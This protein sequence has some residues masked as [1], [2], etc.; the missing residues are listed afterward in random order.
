MFNPQALYDFV[1]C[2]WEEK[3]IPSLC[4]YIRIP[5]KSPHFD[6]KWQEHGL[7]EQAV[8]HIANWCKAHG[9]KG[10][11]LEIMRLKGRT[12]LIFIEVPGVID[13]TVLLYGHLDKQ[14]EM[15]GWNEDLHP[16]KPV[17]KNGRLY[18][19]G[20][21]DD[22]YA[23]YASL[24]AIC[25]LQKQGLP[26]PRCVLIIEACEESGSYDL[27]Y[28]IE[29]LNDRIG[30][31]KLV[32]CLDSGAGNYEQLWMTTSLRGNL[33]G[34]LSVEVIREGVHSGAASGIVA[35]SFR[36]ARQLISRI[37]D[38][39]SGEVKLPELYCDIPEERTR[40]AAQ[41]AQVLGDS[42]YTEFP[43]HKGVE[44]VTIDRKELILNRSWRPALTVTGA[45][46]FPAIEDA[47]NVLRP[48]TALKLSMRLP[49]LV[50][51]EIAATAM[52]NALTEE[53]PYHAKVSFK[54][55]D[56]S[57]GW[58]APKL[59]SWLEKAADA[60]SMTYYGKP[61]AY[62]GEGGTIPFMGMLGKK[63]PDAQFMITG[64]LGPHSNAHG[65]NEF[66]HLDMVKKL[67]A[68]VAYVLYH[69]S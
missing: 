66:L 6:P 37:E 51:P 64:V 9:P 36:V 44:P 32:I 24:T 4:D 48:Q 69:A 7:M 30:K 68:S 1:C 40:Q 43:F 60:A 35:D 53:T 61:A 20:A 13:E 62:L 58:N 39:V 10:M 33:V 21:A 55:G 38:E 28:Y 22:G 52:H 25:A 49:P 65:P 29:L 54:M 23:A 47:G 5:N 57:P 59:A 8:S 42:V 31:P 26:F 16:W 2:Q 50:D 41:C 18:G 19:R 17:L 12:P 46:G 45:N 34:E 27:P 3:I 67:T 56:A 14:P 11:M 63:F 15:S